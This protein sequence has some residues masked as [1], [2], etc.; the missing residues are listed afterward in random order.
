MW[1]AKVPTIVVIPTTEV[2]RV[3]EMILKLLGKLS[4]FLCMSFLAVRA[5][6]LSVAIDATLLL[7][8]EGILLLYPLARAIRQCLK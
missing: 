5:P 6:Q 2:R 7:Y 4:T 8:V 3:Y 1:P